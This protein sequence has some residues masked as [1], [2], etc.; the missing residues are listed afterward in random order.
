[1]KSLLLITFNLNLQVVL[2]GL[3]I[4]FERYLFTCSLQF[5]PYFIFILDPMAKY[6]FYRDKQLIAVSR[7]H[8]TKIQH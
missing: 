2:L 4:Y 1:M 5:S 8:S 7:E 6:N 3:K